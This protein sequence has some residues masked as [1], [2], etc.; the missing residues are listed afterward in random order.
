MNK[1]NRAAGQ[2]AAAAEEASKCGAGASLTEKEQ[3]ETV[4]RQVLEQY[5]PAFQELAK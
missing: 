3:I 1:E 4:A 2:N 5:L